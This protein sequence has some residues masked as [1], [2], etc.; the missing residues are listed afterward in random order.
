[1]HLNKQVNEL[2][3]GSVDSKTYLAGSISVGVRERDMYE[4][5]LLAS[6]QDL[7]VW[8]GQSE[9]EKSEENPS[10]PRH[11]GS[12]KERDKGSA[13]SIRIRVPINVPVSYRGYTFRFRV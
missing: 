13:C 11:G 6:V 2:N 9:R 3:Q 7:I 12:G 10:E 1:M 4:W 5:M 8:E